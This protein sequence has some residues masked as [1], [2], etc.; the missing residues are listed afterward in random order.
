M[1][2]LL[3]SVEHGNY[4]SGTPANILPFQEKKLVGIG[5]P[6]FLYF[7]LKT[8]YKLGYHDVATNVIRRDW[9]DMYDDGFTTCVETFR[10]PNG[11]WGRSVAHAW[12]ASPAI[13]LMTEV[14]GIKPVK[15][16]YTEFAIEPHPTGL[17]F[18]RGAVPTPYGNISVEWTCK[19]GKLEILCEA[20][21]EC[22]RIK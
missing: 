13:F 20:P 21:A 10:L 16:G 22:K 2:I 8:L 17:E 14:L 12:S 6:F 9:G 7:T 4:L 15:P 11:E 3:K 18:A 19:D 1:D 5:S